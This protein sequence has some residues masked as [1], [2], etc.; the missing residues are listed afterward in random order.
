M[1]QFVQSAIEAA[2]QGDKNKAMS[3]LKEVISANPKDADAW[4][5]LAAIIDEPERKRQC[6]NRVLSLDP[7]N[8]LAREE[9][10]E[11][12]RASMGG[13]SPFTAEP[14]PVF[15]SDTSSD[16]AEERLDSV[17]MPKSEPRSQPSMSLESSKPATQPTPTQTKHVSLN[18]WAEKSPKAKAQTRSG[19]KPRAEKPQVFRYSTISRIATYLFA[20][21]FGCSFLLALQDVTLLLIPCGGFF[22]ILPAVWIVSK[23]VELNEKGIRVSSLFGLFVSDVG[24]NEITRIQSKQNALALTTKKGNAVKVT[25]QVVGY[26]VIVETLRQKRPDLFSLA[27]ASPAQSDGLASN[28]AASPSMGYDIPASAPSFSGSK[29]FKKNFFK[30]YGI[31]LIVIPFCFFA[32]WTAYSE[33]DLEY[34]IGAIVSAVFCFV[35]MILPFFQIG[36]VKVEPNKLTVESFIE[37]KAFS[38][39]EIKEIKMASVRGRRGRITNYVNILT[40]QGKNYPVQGF[41]DGDEI[42]YGIL[43]QWWESY[44][45]R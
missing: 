11:M 31:L 24:W 2:N 28:I 40:A 17:S 26:P 22:L 14:S 34:R 32:A 41:S 4:L 10:L 5:V 20:V 35:M 33:T 39:R 16:Q 23:Q 44:R 25:T 37:Q 6:L 7:T 21:I 12:D 27:A 3:F 15:T 42:I 30:Q 8:K 13:A 45:N 43:H 36:L 19:L 9:L 38:A 29:T 1:H 18:D